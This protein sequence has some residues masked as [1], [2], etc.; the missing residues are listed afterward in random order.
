MNG[1]PEQDEFDDEDALDSDD[2]LDDVFRDI[3][4]SRRRSAAPKGGD[5]AW[6]RL[7]RLREEKYT[8]ELTSDFDDYDI[9]F[10]ED[11]GA[12]KVSRRQ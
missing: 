11:G 4:Q 9:G 5:P 2:N 10:D 6:R 8:A 1:R 3:D 12:R 7:E